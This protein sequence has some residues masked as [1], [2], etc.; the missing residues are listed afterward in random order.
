[1]PAKGNVMIFITSIGPRFILLSFDLC[2]SVA[3]AIDS[4]QMGSI[5]PLETIATDCSGKDK[6]YKFCYIIRLQLIS[7]DQACRLKNP[8]LASW[9][10]TK[11]RLVTTYF[12]T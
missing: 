10:V 4:G 7:K 2:S 11:L 5:N 12:R 6:I 3:L 8:V 9:F 1:M